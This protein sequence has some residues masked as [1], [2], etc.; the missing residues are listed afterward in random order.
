MVQVARR[1]QRGQHG[2]VRLS[3][4]AK[5]TLPSEV[6]RLAPRLKATLH[7]NIEKFIQVRA[8]SSC[9]CL[10]YFRR[11]CEIRPF[12]AWPL[13]LCFAFCVCRV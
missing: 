7:R 9:Y 10:R 3:D 11:R 6:L 5:D 4:K 13:T 2:D 1:Q 8:H 12:R